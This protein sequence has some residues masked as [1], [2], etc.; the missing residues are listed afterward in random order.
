MWCVCH[1]VLESMDVYGLVL[2]S[3]LVCDM[4]F[5]VGMRTCVHACGTMGVNVYAVM[6]L[7][8]VLRGIVRVLNI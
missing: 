8:R 7:K 1:R 6:R 5:A 3:T 4:V 2:C